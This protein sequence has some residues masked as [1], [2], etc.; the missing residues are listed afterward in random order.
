[1]TDSLFCLMST[2]HLYLHWTDCLAS[3]L[4][5]TS[6]F[7]EERDRRWCS[8]CKYI[9]MVGRHALLS[10]QNFFRPVDNEVSPLGTAPDHET[11]DNVNLRW[12]PQDLCRSKWAGMSP[13]NIPGQKDIRSTRTGPHRPIYRGCR[14]RTE[15]WWAPVRDHRDLFNTASHQAIQSYIEASWSLSHLSAQATDL[16]NIDL[17][18]RFVRVVSVVRHIDLLA[19]L[20]VKF[21]CGDFVGFAHIHV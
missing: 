10:Y 2:E 14:I 1:M 15:A 11:H 18:R 8:F 19:R 16:A 21:I 9:Y 3:L 7:T 20:L 13:Q 12:S 4:D 5:S 17:S 6:D